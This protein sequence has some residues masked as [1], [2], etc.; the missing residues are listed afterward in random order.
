MGEENNT[1]KQKIGFVPMTKIAT[2][3]PAKLWEQ[4]RKNAAALNAAREA[5]TKSK[6]EVIAVIAKK[7]NLTD[8]E[9]IDISV[10]DERVTVLR[11]PKERKTRAASSLLDLTAAS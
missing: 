7:L 11:R 6:A 3:V 2:V 9:T 5:V 1:G 10:N 8:V 4:H